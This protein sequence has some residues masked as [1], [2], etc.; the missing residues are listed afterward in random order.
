MRLAPA[1]EHIGLAEGFETAWAAMLIHNLRTWATLGE[2]RY[3]LV[4]LPPTTRRVTIFADPDPVG[5]TGAK[6][7]AIA[8]PHIE[9]DIQCPWTSDDYAEIWRAMAKEKP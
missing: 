1:A 6:Q 5:L 2:G 9:T 3:Q 4:K 7:F 8:N